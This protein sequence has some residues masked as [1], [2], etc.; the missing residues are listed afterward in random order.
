M[1]ESDECSIT[2]YSPPRTT[3]ASLFPGT[4]C[5]RVLRSDQKCLCGFLRVRGLAQTLQTGPELQQ[6]TRTFATGAHSHGTAP[7]CNR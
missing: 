7:A 4:P 3:I 6:A 5:L 1:P 2:L